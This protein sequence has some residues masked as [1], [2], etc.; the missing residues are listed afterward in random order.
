MAIRYSS[1]AWSL[2]SGIA[3][4]PT[5]MRNS[6]TALT[7]IRNFSRAPVEFRISVTRVLGFRIYGNAYNTNSQ[8]YEPQNAEPIYSGKIKTLLQHPLQEQQ[9]ST[10]TDKLL[11]IRDGLI[12]SMLWQS[13]FRGFNVGGR[14]LLLV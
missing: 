4:G 14:V 6:R 8:G 10:A 11:L 1:G 9:H 7:R 5:G 12:I 3:V 2:Q 13:C